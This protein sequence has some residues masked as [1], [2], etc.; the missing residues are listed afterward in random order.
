MVTFLFK[1]NF[2]AVCRHVSRGVVYCF[3]QQDGTID[4][5]AYKNVYEKNQQLQCELL[6]LSKENMELRFEA[7]SARIDVPRLKVL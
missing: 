5:A 6:K 1:F 7:E 4:V 3:R 2:L